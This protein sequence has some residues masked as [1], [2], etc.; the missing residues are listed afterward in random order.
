MAEQR[1]ALFPVQA[2]RDDGGGQAYSP[3]T[4]GTAGAF[5]NNSVIARPMA[6][7]RSGLA[8]PVSN[9]SAIG[10]ARAALLPVAGTRRTGRSW[11]TT[12]STEAILSPP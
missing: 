12:R 9:L 2:S 11:P 6:S 10:S 7:T 4:R 1:G 3:R 8:A 5:P